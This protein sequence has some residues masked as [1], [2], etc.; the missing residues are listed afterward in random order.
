MYKQMQTRNETMDKFTYHLAPR[1]KAERAENVASFIEEGLKYN[2]HY[3]YGDLL[4]NF[5]TWSM[6]T[7]Q[8]GVDM[9]NAEYNNYED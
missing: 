2:I 8:A 7:I 9:F 1:T 5:K 6:K 4:N 3:T